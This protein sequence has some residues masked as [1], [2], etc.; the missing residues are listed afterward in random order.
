MDKETIENLQYLQYILHAPK[1]LRSD[2]IKSGNKLFITTFSEALLNIFY[3][4]IV[5]L[6]AEKELFKTHK[7]ICLDIINEKKSFKLKLELVKKLEPQIFDIVYAVL[8]R[9]V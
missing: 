7:K 2:F 4:E 8:D 5:L 3:G 9:Y 1:E 6:E